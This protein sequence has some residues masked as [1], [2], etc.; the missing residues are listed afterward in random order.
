MN[1]WEMAKLRRYYLH[2]EWD[3]G[4]HMWN[5]IWESWQ[6]GFK[7]IPDPHQPSAGYAEDFSC[8]KD[9]E[10]ALKEHERL[11]AVCRELTHV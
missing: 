2:G 10:A 5:D 7:P 11:Q 8:L 3:D 9:F 1:A 6:S 4:V